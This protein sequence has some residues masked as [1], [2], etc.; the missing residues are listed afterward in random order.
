MDFPRTQRAI[1]ML[2][3]KAARNKHNAPHPFQLPFNQGTGAILVLG[4]V[5]NYHRKKIGDDA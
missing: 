2:C 4:T 3:I 1:F 5:T